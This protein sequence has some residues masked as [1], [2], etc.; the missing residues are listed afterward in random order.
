MS[1]PR[2]RCIFNRGR[3]A[4]CLLICL[5][6]LSIQPAQMR[7]E[8]PPSDVSTTT[9]PEIYGAVY[10][11]GSLAK[12]RNLNVGG[13]ELPSTTIKDGAGGGFMAGVYPAFTGYVLG[14]R[15]E[16][17]GLGHE[18]TAPASI[19]SSGAES[20]R[21]NLLAWTTMVSLLIQ[22][23]GKMLKPY[24]GLG[25]GWSSSFFQDVRITKG[26]ITQTGT[27]RDTSPAFQS[28]AGLRTYVTDSVFVFGEYKYFASRY[29][30]AGSL[31]PSLDLRTHI[32]A[33]G[34]GLT[35]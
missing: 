35:F 33:V 20:G 34:A 26:T 7:G 3:M 6:A 22:Y 11:L 8:E 13:Q 1:S 29:H 25:M 28:V 19:G 10:A 27:L 12:N 2:F 15:A 18:V 17:F 5:L 4:W 32:V 23:P 14:V 9:G 30:W 31:E 21:G 16:S 24:I